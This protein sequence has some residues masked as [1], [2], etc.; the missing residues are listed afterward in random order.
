MIKLMNHFMS[1]SWVGGRTVQRTVKPHSPGMCN[2]V[3]RTAFL[4]ATWTWRCFLSLATFRDSTGRIRQCFIRNV[5]IGSLP[6]KHPQNISCISTRCGFPFH[7]GFCHAF[8]GW[9]SRVLGWLFHCLGRRP[10][11]LRL[12][13]RRCG[14]FRYLRFRR[15]R[16]GAWGLGSFRLLLYLLQAL[17]RLTFLW[18]QRWFL[19]CLFL[20]WLQRTLWGNLCGI[21]L[22]RT[23]WRLKQSP[24]WSFNLLWLWFLAQGQ[25]GSLAITRP[26]RPKSGFTFCALHTCWCWGS[27]SF[28]GSCDMKCAYM[29]EYIKSWYDWMMSYVDSQV[30]NGCHGAM[31]LETSKWYSSSTGWGTWFQSTMTPIPCIT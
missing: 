25:S 30:L 13:R 28:F 31:G 17:L 5:V 1:W 6:L 3:S 15:M 4:L 29:W 9:W 18:L 24:T 21:L 20:L 23:M 22:F 11:D 10:W 27:R 8:T 2:F 19:C 26:D 14:S 16:F 7:T 12:S